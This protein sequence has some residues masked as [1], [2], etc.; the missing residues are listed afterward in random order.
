MRMGETTYVDTWKA[1]QEIMKRTRKARAIGVSN[2]SR[3]ETK[4]LINAEMVSFFLVP[5]S[6]AYDGG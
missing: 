4:N 5:L 2:F 3:D 1:L 6:Q